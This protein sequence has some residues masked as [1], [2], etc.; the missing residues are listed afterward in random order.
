M[1]NQTKQ[2]LLIM[3]IYCNVDS[4]MK[5]F[6]PGLTTYLFLLTNSLTL[7]VQTLYIFIILGS[8]SELVFQS[9]GRSQ[10][11]LSSTVLWISSINLITHKPCKQLDLPK[12]I[13][14]LAC[15]QILLSS[16]SS[17]RWWWPPW[18]W[19]Q[20]TMH[21]SCFFI[22]LQ[23]SNDLS[24]LEEDLST[25]MQGYKSTHSFWFSSCLQEPHCLW[26]VR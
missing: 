19:W 18:Q 3:R 13:S 7:L 24:L 26:M 11:I 12:Q 20:M 5:S 15:R 14:P 9:A 22:S 6:F 4:L 25:N 16:L 8:I 2:I 23:L 17:L 10:I 21:C 1:H